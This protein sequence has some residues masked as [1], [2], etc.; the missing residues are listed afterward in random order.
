MRLRAFA[1]IPLAGS[2]Y[3]RSWRPTRHLIRASALS[4]ASGKGH[5]L[6]LVAVSPYPTTHFMETYPI[7]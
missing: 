3:E 6:P 7:G 4:A 5:V 2:A 1:L